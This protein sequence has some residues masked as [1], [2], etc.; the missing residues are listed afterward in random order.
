MHV[1]TGFIIAKLIEQLYNDPIFYLIWPVWH[2]TFLINL[3]PY[4][5]SGN[6][7]YFSRS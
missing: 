4:M 5:S 7:Y 2:K 1:K 3:S 6:I